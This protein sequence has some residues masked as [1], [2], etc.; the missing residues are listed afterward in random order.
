[1][2]KKA[3]VISG[4]SFLLVL[5]GVLTCL[6]RVDPGYV[7][8]VYSMSG[9]IQNSS[10]QQGY[11]LISPT[12]NVSQ[13]TVGTEQGN[14]SSSSQEG[15]KDDE[16]FTIPTR[17]GKMIRVDVEYAYSFIP[18]MIP[19]TFTRFRGQDGQSIE[20]TF[21]KSKIKAWI[22]EV[23]AN[24][25]VIEIYGERRADLNVD[26]LE[27]LTP[28]F[29]E[30]GINLETINIT[31]IQLDEATAQA[32]QRRVNAQ[33]ELE[34]QRVQKEKAEIEA[35]RKL[36]EAKGRSEALI[37]QARGEYEANKLK[38]KSLTPE[39]LREMELDARKEH[40]WV[41]VQG[42]NPIVDTRP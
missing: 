29:E 33:Q 11:H 31:Q 34:E 24:Y 42:G 22:A 41:T 17:D 38:S 16:S 18:E 26:I 19:E 21:M 6:V 14:L 20:H 39:V 10:L 27:H 4:V 23:S 12:S 35:E 40:G 25:P 28:K 2:Q 1:M 32:I 5:I 7:G 13:F 37:E 15:S 30:Y 36:V 8:V 9:G 3:I